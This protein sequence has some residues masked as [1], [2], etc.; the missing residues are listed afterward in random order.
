MTESA[1]ALEYVF[2]AD[3]FSHNIPMWEQWLAPLAGKPWIQGLEI[4]SHQGRSTIWLLDKIFTAENSR[5]YCVDTFEGSVEHAA[6]DKASLYEIFTHNVRT[7]G[8]LDRVQVMR[9]ESQTILRHIE[10]K[11]FFDFIYIDGDHHASAVLEDAILCFP[12]LKDGGILIFDDF[13]WGG[14]SHD[15]Q[16]P[17]IAVEGFFHAMREHVD[18][19]GSGYQ[20]AVRKKAP[21]ASA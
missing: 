2:T 20:V 16:R 8:H 13:L 3:F 11:A 18:L 4:G 9:G 5:L 7:A 12:L 15:W 6:R 14:M 10:R 21:N 17:K 19:L 1:P